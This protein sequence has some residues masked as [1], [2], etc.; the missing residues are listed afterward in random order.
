MR[1]IARIAAAELDS[2][3]GLE[4]FRMPRGTPTAAVLHATAMGMAEAA[5][6][7]ASIFIDAGLPTDFLTSFRAAADAMLGSLGSRRQQ[8]GSRCGA[9]TGLKETI[10][11]ARKIVDVLDAFVS[12]A[13]KD[14]AALLANWKSV[15]RPPAKPGKAAGTVVASAQPQVQDHVPVYALPS[16]DGLFA[17]FLTVGTINWSAVRQRAAREPVAVRVHGPRLQHTETLEA[18]HMR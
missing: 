6:P 15:K 9:T 11:S 10:R 2:E 13:L 16:R 8:Q 7:H 4:V 17:R 18:V 12:V 1:P 5:E 3:P 14:D